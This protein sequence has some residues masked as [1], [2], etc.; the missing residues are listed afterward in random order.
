MI[1][2]NASAFQDVDFLKASLTNFSD[3]ATLDR[4]WSHIFVTPSTW[5]LLA[6]SSSM[7]ELKAILGG[8]EQWSGLGW[9]T[10]SAAKNLYAISGVALVESS[11]PPYRAA[12][13]CGLSLIW[14]IEFGQASLPDSVAKAAFALSERADAVES[15]GQEAAAG[16]PPPPVD[17]GE[18]GADTDDRIIL[19][20]DTEEWPMSP[21]VAEAWRR[22][23][24]SEFP[25]LP[26]KDILENIPVMQGIP[27]Y[28]PDNNHRA[29]AKNKHDQAHKLWQGQ[30]LHISRMLA[31]VGTCIEDGDPPE[32]LSLPD[33]LLAVFHVVAD[34]EKRIENF[35]KSSSIPHS[36][37]IPNQLFAKSDIQVAELTK[38]INK[39]GGGGGGSGK[40]K[41]KGIRDGRGKGKGFPAG[42]S[43]GF[44]K[45]KG[46]GRGG[47]GY[48]GGQSAQ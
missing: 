35:R 27:R 47:G 4:A 40:G 1:A 25:P 11:F 6:D 32:D 22:S 36:V 19:P 24:S 38:K 13:M 29:D 21:L 45:K 30:L 37:E 5:K 18:G 14:N 42:F 44:S 48:P 20:F 9:T 2:D 12:F 31:F 39:F 10:A 46:K 15:P 8:G 26:L 43:S 3:S 33:T 23:R 41:G 28:P 16:K 7:E 34:L 17:S